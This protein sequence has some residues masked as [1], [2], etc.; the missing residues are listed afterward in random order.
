MYHRTSA[1]ARRE[2]KGAL[3]GSA[4]DPRVVLWA[5]ARRADRR[6]NARALLAV[7]DD[8]VDEAVLLGLRGRHD[9]VALDVA[10]DLLEGLAGV[11]GDDVGGQLAHAD[12]LLG[13]NLDV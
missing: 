11:L 10:L 12:D 8:L 2:S 3:K 1:G 9:A 4:R 13:L 5:F 7:R 6:A